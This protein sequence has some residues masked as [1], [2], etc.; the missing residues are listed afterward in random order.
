MSDMSQVVKRP[1]IAKKK[2]PRPMQWLADVDVH[3]ETMREREVI[4]QV[5]LEDCAMQANVQCT[6]ERDEG[7]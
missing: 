3:E 2:R 1:M 4:P 6:R 5:R 7:L